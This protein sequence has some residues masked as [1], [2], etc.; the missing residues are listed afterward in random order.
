[1]LTVGMGDYNN[2]ILRGDF[3]DFDRLYFAISK[4]TGDYGIENSC[5]FPGYEAIC[6]S[7]LGLCYELRKAQEGKRELYEQYNGIPEEWFEEK[8]EIVDKLNDMYDSEHAF[9]DV[10]DNDSIDEDTNFDAFFSKKDF[11]N[12]T[13]T[14]TLLQLQLPFS[15]A[16]YYALIFR[17]LLE[18]KDLFLEQRKKMT[19]NKEN[20]M[21]ELN[22]EYYYC[23]SHT[24]LARI[25]IYMESVFRALYHLIGKDDYIRYI[26]LFSSKPDGF[27]NC[28][29]QASHELVV[30][31]SK[32]ISKNNDTN[33]LIA[34]L[35]KLYKEMC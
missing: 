20:D 25:T 21:H 26:D 22:L 1:M 31:Y 35:D 8:S 3:W 17:E 10:E 5:P 18:K 12:T 4:F 27:M 2:V 13:T 34:Y 32:E 24:D 33:N 9:D 6:E 11:P 29:L 19:K 30:E 28:D 23:Q 15:E 16:L 7:L 14:N